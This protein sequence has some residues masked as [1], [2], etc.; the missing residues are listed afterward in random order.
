MSDKTIDLSTERSGRTTPRLEKGSAV[1]KAPSSLKCPLGR[2]A[3]RGA[4]A[5]DLRPRLWRFF[6]LG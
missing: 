4:R 3:E 5:V 2:H 6:F 1:H